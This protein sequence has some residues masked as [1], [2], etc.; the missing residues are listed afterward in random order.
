[1]SDLE[2]P[3]EKDRRGHYR[4][5]EI[6]PGALSYLLI[7]LP[8]AL[9]FVN[10]SLAVFFI[11]FYL[12]IFFVRGLGYSLRAVSGYRTMKKHMKLDW[13]ALSAEIDAGKLGKAQIT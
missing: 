3:F 11:L 10:V 12:L 13:N 6:L 9:T 2:I 7:I 1:M 5:F 4:F 8:V